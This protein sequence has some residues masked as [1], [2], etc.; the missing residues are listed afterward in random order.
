MTDDNRPLADHLRENIPLLE[1][2]ARDPKK[3][4][5]LRQELAAQRDLRQQFLETTSN[6]EE[7]IR[8]AEGMIEQASAGVARCDD[9]IAIFE[10]VLGSS[11]SL[12]A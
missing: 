2:A 3:R 9:A 11:G 1:Q 10:R 5:R 12:E 6:A 7:R 4:G 8:I